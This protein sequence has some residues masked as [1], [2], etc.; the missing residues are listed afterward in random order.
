M[1]KYEAVK[2]VVHYE[3]ASQPSASKTDIGEV[4]AL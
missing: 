4:K 2:Q 1:S 3:E